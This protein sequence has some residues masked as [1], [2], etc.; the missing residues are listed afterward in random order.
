MF[1]LIMPLVLLCR[2]MA[3]NAEISISYFGL[4]LEKRI[5]GVNPSWQSDFGI[6]FCFWTQGLL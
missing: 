1:L 2:K 5:I 3:M 6:I 4:L